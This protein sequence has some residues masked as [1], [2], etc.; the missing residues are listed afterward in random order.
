M[1][2]D[3]R[4]WDKLIGVKP[5][6]LHSQ[7]IGG[8]NEVKILANLPPR[9]VISTFKVWSETHFESVLGR[10]WF[11]FSWLVGWK[12]AAASI[13]F[14]PGYKRKR[15][16]STHFIHSYTLLSYAFLKSQGI[17]TL[18]STQ[19]PLLCYITTYIHNRAT[20]TF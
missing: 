15:K 6:P 20:E 18:S 7:I 12:C 9:R 17:F 5:P 11:Y 4:G 10:F 8:S 1:S 16:R 14:A 19:L 13:K 2:G 3:G